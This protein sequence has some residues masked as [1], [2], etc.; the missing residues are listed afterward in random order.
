MNTQVNR[1]KGIVAGAMFATIA[2]T[3][4]VADDT[5]LLLQNQATAQQNKPNIM[6]IIDT[7]GSM[8]T[9]ETIKEPYDA[10]QTYGGSC[11]S[12]RLY[13]TDA[14]IEPD[15]SQ[16]GNDRYVDKSS[17]VCAAATGPLIGIGRY[18]NTMV[19]RRA[20]EG[21][22]IMRWQTLE[23]GNNTDL[24][25]CEADNGVHGDGTPGDV[26]PSGS[27]ATAFVSSANNGL[28]W[29]SVPAATGY[30]VYDG[31]YLNWQESAPDDDLERIEIVQSVTKA[32]LRS[33]SN[34]NVGFMRFNDSAGGPV[35][36]AIV[37]L[38][39]NRTA[40]ENTIDSLDDDG[41]T[42]L[43]ETLYESAL[44][45]R[46][47]EAFFGEN[48][49]EHATDPGALVSNNPEVYAQPTTN[50]CSKNFNVLLT[51]GSPV[52][53]DQTPELILNLPDYSAVTG[54]TACI[55]P[56]AGQRNEPPEA[57]LCLDDI[58]S[59]LFNGDI[60][61][62]L[63][64]VQR[65]TT[66]TI[67]F[68]I[69]PNDSELVRTANL[70]RATAE[71]SQ[72][73]YFL[74]DDAESLAITLLNI[75]DDITGP[76]LSFAAPAVSVNA[77]NRTQNLNDL[78]LT[79]FGAKTRVHWPGNLKKYR[80]ANGQIVDD[81]GVPAVNPATGFFLNSAR[82][83]WSSVVDGSDVTLGGAANRLPSPASGR[84]LYT[85]N[86]ISNRLTANS[87]ALA[88]GNAGAF[89]DSDFGLTGASSEPS[90]ADLIR[91]MR[92]QDIRDEDNNPATSTRFVMG[93]PLH[94]QP[95]AVVYGGTEADPDLVVFTA[96]N[97]GY[98]HA[99][100][101][102]TGDELWAF[103]PR[104]LLGNMT[105]LFFDPRS[106]FKN[107][108]ID[109]NIVPVVKDNDNDGIIEPGDDDFVYLIFGLRRGGGS[110]YALDVSNKAAP[111]LMWV[112]SEPERGQSWSTPTVARMDIDDARLNSDKAVVV[113]GGGYDPVHDMPAHPSS[114]DAQ[115]AGVHILDLVSGNRLWWAGPTGSGANLELSD[116]TRSI[117]TQVRVIDLTGDGLA[118]RMYA[119]D[120]GG[121]LWRFDIDGGEAPNSLVAAG[122]H[123]RLGAEGLDAPSAADTRRFYSSV[124]VSV[125]TD[126]NIGRRY[127][128]LSI[129]SGY[130]A[131]PLDNSA[132]DR[133]YSV[134]DDNLFGFMDQ[135]AHNDFTP[136]TEA[137]LVEVAGDV[138]V[139]ITST[140]RGWKFTLPPNQKVIT[141]SAT[142]DNSVFFI[143]FSPEANTS[144]PCEPSQGRNF[145]YRVN[146][147]NGDPV[148][149]NL[150][151]IAPA[152][153]DEARVTALQQG[154]IAPTP[155]F[156]FP[157]P[158]ADCIGAACSPPPIGC[159]GV[160]CFNP[161]FVNNP[162][163]TLWSEDRIN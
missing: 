48:I 88:P 127:A 27:V 122:V 85:N 159:V 92:G 75:V 74:A 68:A 5:E 151:A 35:I 131:H 57:G 90:K 22:S 49:N 158:P 160:E 28:A 72:G 77:F 10:N 31:N 98:L 63:P 65:V 128:A 101:G 141:E 55:G 93:D 114:P 53:D 152:D 8:G 108:G 126:T 13:W 163:R 134:R 94:S 106:R 138:R 4:V 38:D 69:D 9:E 58:A 84:N 6:F 30:T 41:A 3:P 149:N 130:R 25:E 17:F 60:D 11:D 110:Y 135:Q 145:L 67:G 56:G 132:S 136:I 147:V 64:G 47:Q 2:A 33:I 97:D 124:D 32:V 120:M 86:G 148:V 50:A 80:L 34:V 91:W 109:G 121:Q 16:T 23:P 139:T 78:Y 117:P 26:Y 133:F 116:M 71:V 81:T 59:Y 157:S 66:H 79:V 54:E 82:S 137:D 36:Q 39:T 15:C 103:V 87:N 46:G 140:D 112:S 40:I 45:W 51:D 111:E 125:F 115:G 104:E 44:Y 113:I 100:D 12:G 24:V 161:G 1:A 162:V 146:V 70:L 144:D 153:A 107:Y 95:A 21:G 150:D 123:A 43:S 42:P 118:D 99:I 18:S 7:S 14:G 156:L 37:D 73:S 129:G 62:G 52:N 155:T 19:Q 105:R 61:A 154:G 142:F 83:V 89:S 76:S 29:G 143:G 20:Q 102:E 119:A 96:T